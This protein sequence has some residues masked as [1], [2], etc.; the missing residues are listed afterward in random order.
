MAIV[1]IPNTM[2]LSRTTALIA[3]ALA[4]SA[5]LVACSGEPP[6]PPPPPT[7]VNTAE[8]LRARMEARK[9]HNKLVVDEDLVAWYIPC[10]PSAASWVAPI[11]VHHLPSMS[12]VHLNND[13]SLKTSP[14]PRYGSDEGRERLAAVLADD[15]LMAR[16][17]GKWNDP[18]HCPPG[19]RDM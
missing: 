15:A 1:E 2:I 13:G 3:F 8:G 10:E 18:D 19:S 4:T 7:P 9:N 17:V 12:S 16:I 14:G 5:L 11:I 6:Y